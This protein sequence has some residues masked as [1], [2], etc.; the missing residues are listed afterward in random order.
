MAN[1]FS[2]KNGGVPKK[3]SFDYSPVK[4][5]ENP[6]STSAAVLNAVEEINEELGSAA[7]CSN[8]SGGENSSRLGGGGKSSSSNS[9][10]RRLSNRT[11]N[12]K[13]K[14]ATGLSES[15]ALSSENYHD[16]CESGGLGVDIRG[17][18]ITNG[19]VVSG[20]L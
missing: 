9:F 7:S 3:N 11:K 5:S 6:A 19:N 17:G 13:G 4:G 15:A 1:S 18:T 10:F 2:N 8:S 12:T 16:L 20:L 14:A